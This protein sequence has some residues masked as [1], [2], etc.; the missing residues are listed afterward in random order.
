MKKN[1][2]SHDY[3]QVTAE[4]FEVLVDPKPVFPAKPAIG[5]KVDPIPGHGE[6][7]IMPIEY[8]TALNVAMLIMKTL[9][10]QAPQLFKGKLFG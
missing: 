1:I 9:L 2:K 4:S 10:V 7:F 3:R 8:E 6:S 5:L